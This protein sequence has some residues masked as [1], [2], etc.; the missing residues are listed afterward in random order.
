MEL[1]PSEPECPLNDQVELRARLREWQQDRVSE[2]EFI[3][4]DR[5]RRCDLINRDIDLQEDGYIEF[6]DQCAILGEA[7]PLC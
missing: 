3:V 7:W 4:L 1:K 6:F 2:F 5:E